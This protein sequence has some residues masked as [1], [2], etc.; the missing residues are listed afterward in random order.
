MPWDACTWALPQLPRATARGMGGSSVGS[1]PTDGI[2]M[3]SSSAVGTGHPPPS[4]L[5]LRTALYPEG[6]RLRQTALTVS[7]FRKATHAPE[8][9]V[10][11]PA[12]HTRSLHTTRGSLYQPRDSND[13]VIRGEEVRCFL[14]PQVTFTSATDSLSPD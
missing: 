6:D 11:P 1:L 10:P 12:P 2:Q 3:P 7:V 13:D 4:S 9:F 8:M 5:W 14:L